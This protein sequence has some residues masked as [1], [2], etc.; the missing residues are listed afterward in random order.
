MC[1]RVG[2]YDAMYF[3]SVV[4]RWRGAAQAATQPPPPQ[5]CWHFGLL[6]CQLASP[7]S[8]FHHCTIKHGGRGFCCIR[9]TTSRCQFKGSRGVGGVGIP[10][11]PKKYPRIGQIVVSLP[12]S[13]DEASRSPGQRHS[14]RTAERGPCE[15]RRPMQELP[16]AGEHNLCRDRISK[17]KAKPHHETPARSH[18]VFG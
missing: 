15:A 13:R 7:D 2:V 5:G 6:L 3:L 18:Q 17:S 4:A 11:K 16:R 12:H 8:H 9:V 10:Q 1:A 14:T